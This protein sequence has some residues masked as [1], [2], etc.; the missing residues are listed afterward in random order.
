[1]RTAHDIFAVYAQ[2]IRLHLPSFTDK[3][4][5]RFAHRG[6]TQSSR[7][8]GVWQYENGEHIG[9]SP[10]GIPYLETHLSRINMLTLK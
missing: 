10:A 8:Q 2:R 5:N 1:M 3:P 7:V 4:S 6:L 9:K